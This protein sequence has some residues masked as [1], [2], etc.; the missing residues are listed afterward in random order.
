MPDTEPSQSPSLQRCADAT[1]ESLYSNLSKLRAMFSMIEGPRFDAF[2][3]MDEDMQA[4]YMW[5]CAD[6]AREIDTA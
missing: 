2:R 4:K 6:F 1:R 5:A 3:Q